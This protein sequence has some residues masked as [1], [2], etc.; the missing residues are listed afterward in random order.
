MRKVDQILA[1]RSAGDVE[2]CHAVPHHG[3]YSNARH[4]YGAVTLLLLLHPSPSM[5]LLKAIQFHDVA[6]YWLGD[7][8]HPAK[9]AMP[10]VRALHHRYEVLKLCEVFGSWPELDDEDLAWLAAVDQMDYALWAMDQYA[11]GNT[12]ILDS[13]SASWRHIGELNLPREAREFWAE[14]SLKVSF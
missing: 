2:R 8:P 1:V 6:E 7:L 13:L 4:C 9:M 12:K 5:E 11:M 10:D 3:S 14:L